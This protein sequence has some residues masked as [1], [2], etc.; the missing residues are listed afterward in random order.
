MKPFLLFLIGAPLVFSFIFSLVLLFMM[1]DK[2]FRVDV[3]MPFFLVSGLCG[4]LA[5][6][7]KKA[8]SH[9]GSLLKV[10]GDEHVPEKELR[11]QSN[12]LIFTTYVGLAITGL[13]FFGYEIIKGGLG[14]LAVMMGLGLLWSG[15]Q[16]IRAPIPIARTPEFWVA[17]AVY[18]RRAKLF[19]LFVV[20]LA[21]TVTMAYRFVPSWQHISP[22][23]LAGGLFLLASS[24]AWLAMSEYK[25]RIDK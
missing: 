23:D 15:F 10:P 5:F 18:P 4:Y 2:G 9:Q 8:L 6:L 12:I 16:V 22:W 19:Y 14:V 11:I 20:G 1:F 24:C 17:R 21:I 3:L 7:F 25:R 13:I